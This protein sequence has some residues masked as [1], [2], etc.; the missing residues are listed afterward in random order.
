MAAVNKENT[1]AEMVVRRLLHKLG[2]RYRLHVRT[3]I[4][5]PDIVMKKWN[6]IIFVNGCYWHGHDCAHGNRQSR[7]NVTY[8]SE[9]IAKN[10]ERDNRVLLMLQELGWRTLV[11]WE[12]GLAEKLELENG[13]IAFLKNRSQYNSTFPRGKTDHKKV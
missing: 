6:A 9:K 5:R 4:G 2:Y 1:S 3:L 10:R 11:A 7:T 13:L 12:C 8:W